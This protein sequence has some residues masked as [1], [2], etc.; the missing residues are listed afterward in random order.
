VTIEDPEGCPRYLAQVVRGVTIAPSPPWLVERLE[1]TGMRAINNVVDVTN[2]VMLEMGQPLHAF[3]LDT[4]DGPAIVVRRARAG[5]KLTTLDDKERALTGE[6]LVIADRA[7]A[8]GLAGTMG[9]AFVEVTAGTTNLLLEAAWFDPVRVQRMVADFGLMS[10]AARRFG[11]GVDP[12]LAPAAMARALALF[13]ELA[14][15]KLDGPATDVR[16]ARVAPLE[17]ELR[18]ARATRLL[19]MRVSRARMFKDLTASGLAVADPLGA[20]GAGEEEPAETPLI[21]T[22]PTRRRDLTAEV[23]LIE[24]VARGAGYDRLPEVPLTTGGSVGERPAQRRLEDRVR[25]ALVGLGF[26]ECLTPSLEDPARLARTWPLTRAGDAAPA[27]IANPAGPETSAL[28][29]DLVCGLLR[30]AAHNL[31]HGADGLRLFEIGRVFVPR[32]GAA[33]PTELDEVTAVVS[34]RRFAEA[35]DKAQADVDFFETK[36]LWEALLERL[37]VDT[38]VWAPYAGRGW[39]S[40]EIAQL[41][42]KVHV[43]WAG[44]LAPRLLREFDIETPAYVFTTALAALDRPRAQARRYAGYSRLPAIK[45]DLAFFVPREVSHAQVEQLLRTHGAP[46]L[47]GAR[48]FDVYEGK[49]VP[50]GQKSLAYSLTFQASDRTLT[51][52]EIESVQSTLVAALGRETGAVLRER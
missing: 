46:L 18:P 9:A 28:R 5:E 42:G 11:R 20:G 17:L 13:G 12:A 26:T 16:H 6:H 49:G 2:Y 31:R 4:L 51:D 47:V 36:G 52:A 8:T 44:R 3:D 22:V 50:E 19:G 41:R 40:G 21:V 39:K 33:L 7:R 27:L 14:G 30:T 32:D 35:W 23:D 29:S 48:L 43:A 15:G 34:G 45:R 37:G 24:E 10:E 38:A 25:D 1:R